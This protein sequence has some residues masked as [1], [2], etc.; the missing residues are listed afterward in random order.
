MALP[1]VPPGSTGRVWLF[2]LDNTLHD[3]SHAA[4]APIS[5]AMTRYIEAHTGL[6]EA[7]A[8]ELRQHYWKRY[9]ATLLG[10]VR[11]HAVRADHFLEQTHVLPGLEARLRTSAHDRAALDRLRGR[12]YVLTNAPRR[13]ALRVLATLRLT[14][15]FDGVIAIEDMAMFGALRPKPD[16]RMLRRVAARL[17]VPADR[18][19]LVEDTLEHQKAARSIGMKTVWMQRYLGG[20]FRGHPGRPQKRRLPRAEVGVHRLPKPGYVYARISS[21]RQ[22]LRGR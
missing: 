18:C 9:G 3:A 10:L 15:S 19:W 12:K 7:A 22:L 16:R 11:H 6:E 14:Q 13:Y 21:L 17:G 20:R 2:D 1:R 8:T 5:A 4:F